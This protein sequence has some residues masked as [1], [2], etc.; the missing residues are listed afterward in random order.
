MPNFFLNEKL[1]GND[2]YLFSYSSSSSSYWKLNHRLLEILIPLTH[3]LGHP[4]E[5]AP[6]MSMAGLKN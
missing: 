6:K 4:F 5:A 2:G 3:K 1:L